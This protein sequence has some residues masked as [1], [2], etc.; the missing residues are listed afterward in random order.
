VTL[1][2]VAGARLQRG[3]VCVPP[4]AGTCVLRWAQEHD[5]PWDW[6]TCVRAAKGRQLEGDAVDAGAPL[7]VGCDERVKPPL[8]HLPVMHGALENGAPCG[9]ARVRARA[10]AG[11]HHGK[12]AKWL[13][14]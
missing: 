13:T 4:R 9:A 2:W 14:H 1:R 7:P 8:G 11:G 10:A 6:I 3:P 5:C 12:L